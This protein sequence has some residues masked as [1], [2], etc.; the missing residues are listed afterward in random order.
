MPLFQRIPGDVSSLEVVDP[1]ATAHDFREVQIPSIDNSNTVMWGQN[2]LQPT[3]NQHSIFYN[4]QSSIFHSEPEEP[5]ASTPAANAFPMDDFHPGITDPLALGQPHDDMQIRL[6]SNGIFTRVGVTDQAPT[7]SMIDG[8]TGL[9]WNASKESPTTSNVSPHNR[10][11][12]YPVSSYQL[13]A[14]DTLEFLRR[15]STVSANV[16]EASGT[17]DISNQAQD[18]VEDSAE[19]STNS[20]CSFRENIMRWV[21]EGPSPSASEVGGNGFRV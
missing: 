13:V 5:R 2:N 17:T 15:N 11:V 18:G 8:G 1:E 9:D 19:E 3:G 4:L 21:E 20:G 16:G 14:E 10:H 6:P 12:L 7:S